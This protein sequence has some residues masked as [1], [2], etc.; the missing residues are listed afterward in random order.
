MT[1]GAWTAPHALAVAPGEAAPPAARRGAHHPHRGP[2]GPRAGARVAVR[3]RRGCDGPVDTAAGRA[4]DDR[5]RALRRRATGST[6]SR[7][8]SGGRWTISRGSGARSRTSTTS[9]W[10]RERVLGRREMPGAE[11]FPGARLNYAEHMLGDDARCGGDRRALEHARADRADLRRVARPGRPCA[12]RADAARRRPRRP[13]R[14]LPAEHPGDARRV[15]GDGEPGRDLGERLAR[16]RRPQRD[17]PARADRAQGAA[18]RST[19][20]R[21]ATRAST[22]GRRSPRSRPGCRRSST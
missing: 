22:G 6:R 8:C 2:R 4:R 5:D 12:G 14:R 13:R 11:W 3:G 9:G 21:S 19:A 15:P 18:G 7:R 17:R 20:T 10:T 1:D 16:V